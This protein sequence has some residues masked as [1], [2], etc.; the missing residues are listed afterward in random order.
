MRQYVLTRLGGPRIGQPKARRNRAGLLAPFDLPNWR[1]VVYF[2]GAVDAIEP[3]SGVVCFLFHFMV[4]FVL[5]LSLPRGL[6]WVTSIQLLVH[7]VLR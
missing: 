5:F 2:G 6:L 1:K 3:T 4:C 7:F